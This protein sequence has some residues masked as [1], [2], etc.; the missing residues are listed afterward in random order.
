MST[1]SD[2]PEGSR[3]KLPALSLLTR[4]GYRYLPPDEALT[5]RGGEKAL[6]QQL[7]TGKRRIRI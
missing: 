6:M 3:S 7:L 2:T 1:I 5:L 4:L